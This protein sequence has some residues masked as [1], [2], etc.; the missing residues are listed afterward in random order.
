[1]FI[2]ATRFIITNTTC[3]TR[4]TKLFCYGFENNITANSAQHTGCR[5]ADLYVI[6]TNRFSET[7]NILYIIHQQY[8]A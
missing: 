7:F 6:F 3:T 5:G 8:A 4:L 2:L 1:M